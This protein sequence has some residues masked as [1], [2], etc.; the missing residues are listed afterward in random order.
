MSI[1]LNC[2][3]IRKYM[4]YVDLVFILTVFLVVILRTGVLHAKIQ[5]TLYWNERS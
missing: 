4:V 2:V 3:R 1:D 5:L